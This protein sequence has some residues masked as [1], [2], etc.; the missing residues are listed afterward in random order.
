MELLHT[1]TLEEA[2]EKLKLQ[3]ADFKLRTYAVSCADSLGCI[4]GEDVTAGENVP[5]FRRSTVDGYAV[6]AGET[7]GA[8]DA[9]PIF[10]GCPVMW[11]LKKEQRLACIPERRF[12]YRQDR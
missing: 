5:P 7:Y 12:S 1:D 6:I 3:T 10:S 11:I 8:G 9:N 2:R 4:C